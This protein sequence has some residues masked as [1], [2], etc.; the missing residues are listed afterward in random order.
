M[1]TEQITTVGTPPQ[2]PHKTR[3]EPRPS[4]LLSSGPS[5]TCR[6]TE[7]RVLYVAAH[8]ILHGG[9]GVQEASTVPLP[10]CVCTSV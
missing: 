10:S 3:S 7:R 8:L 6:R 1:N 5:P 4:C 2:K 9:Q